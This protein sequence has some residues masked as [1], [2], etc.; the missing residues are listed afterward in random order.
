MFV[1]VTL[2]LYLGMKLIPYQGIDGHHGK[3][4]PLKSFQQK[5]YSTKSNNRQILRTE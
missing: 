5:I 3:N 1:K 4:C 2:L